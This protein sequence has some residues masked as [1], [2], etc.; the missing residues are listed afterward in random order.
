MK[1]KENI[2]KWN[3]EKYNSNIELYNKYQVQL[4][5][6]NANTH[7]IS[8]FK[9]YLF[10]DDFTEFFSKF[11]PKRE[12][13]ELLGP[14]FAYYEKS[15]Y[16]FPNYT[17]LNEGKYVY[18]NIIKKQ[19][20]IDYLED[21]EIKKKKNNLNRNKKDM[22][23]SNNNEKIFDTQLYNNIISNN[24]NNSNINLLFGLDVK[25]RTRLNTKNNSKNNSKK[26]IENDSI[27]TLRKLIKVIN[28][29]YTRSVGTN[30]VD[31]CMDKKT[32]KNIK[33]RKKISPK[34]VSNS[35]NYIS[36]ISNININSMFRIDKK[37]HI[38]NNNINNNNN[39][40]NN[41]H[42]SNIT[43][44]KNMPNDYYSNLNCYTQKNM[45]VNNK[46]CKINTQ[47]KMNSYLINFNSSFMKSF[48]NKVKGKKITSDKNVFHFIKSKNKNICMKSNT[49]ISK[50]KHVLTPIESIKR[51]ISICSSILKETKINTY[52][53]HLPSIEHCS[54]INLK[55]KKIKII[56]N[57]KKNKNKLS[58]HSQTKSKFDIKL[59]ENKNKKNVIKNNKNN[60][61]R[62][63][64]N[65]KIITDLNLN[66]LKKNN[67]SVS[68]NNS[69]YKT[70]NMNNIKKSTIP[71]TQYR[72]DKKISLCSE[73][74]K[75]EVNNFVK[76][77]YCT[78]N[79]SK[80]KITPITYNDD[81]RKK[82]NVKI[83]TSYF[84]TKLPSP[85]KPKGNLLKYHFN[86]LQKNK[87]KSLIKAYKTLHNSKYFTKKSSH[88]ILLSNNKK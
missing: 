34:E 33:K 69:I 10:Y 17:V 24:G 66:Y 21:I 3:L 1:Y 71:L 85:R 79:I 29:S 6:E 59:F 80:R 48:L 28:D 75:N 5:M 56:N 37:L 38:S 25:A 30:T 45:K 23:K 32:L 51:H 35:T 27:M 13:A 61:H 7:L 41:R 14:L 16:I 82:N 81:E 74:L 68:L 73:F 77:K 64:R 76:K 53:N 72:K 62:H 2:I 78:K 8:T 49:N 54:R 12:S 4:F 67:E 40:N 50:K 52:L 63:Q 57:K 15:S 87:N 47:K 36:N 70:I 44:E 65:K 43:I 19:L 55:Y 26:Y 42:I 83:I 60:Y 39:Q 58:S 86:L 84:S 46:L 22:I 88:V 20:L 9:D 11:Y 18:K 31:V